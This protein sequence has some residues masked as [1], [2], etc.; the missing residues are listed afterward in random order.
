M[1][2]QV[3]CQFLQFDGDVAGAW[4][5]LD[6]DL[7]AFISL[8]ELD[9]DG[10]SLLM[11]FKSYVE[12]GFGSVSRGFSSADKDKSGELTSLE[13]RRACRRLRWHGDCRLLF[14]ALNSEPRGSGRRTLSM[15]EVAYL[16][17]Y[18]DELENDLPNQ[19]DI[20]QHSKKSGSKKDVRKLSPEEFD[21]SG[22]SFYCTRTKFEHKIWSDVRSTQQVQY[23]AQKDPKKFRRRLDAAKTRLEMAQTAPGGFALPPAGSAHAVHKP[24]TTNGVRKTG[25]DDPWYCPHIDEGT[26]RSLTQNFGFNMLPQNSTKLRENLSLPVL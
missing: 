11:C 3:A 21:R 6:S 7:S 20:Y 8:R 22:F 2:F 5:A 1:E 17:S 4:R 24:L 13:F 18:G 12:R 14:D 9:P 25:I 19:R 10:H 23:E 15:Q 16:D 26:R